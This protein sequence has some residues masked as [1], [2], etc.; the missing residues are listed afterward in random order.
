MAPIV[1]I[2]IGNVLLGDD[3]VGVRVVE[4]LGCLA[5][6]DPTMLP[7]VTHLLDG[8]TLG[9]DLMRTVEGAR[10][11]LLVDGVDLGAAPG[12]VVVLRGDEI[13]TAG[14]RRPGGQAG[15]I[16]E[17]LA[18]ARLMG[19]LT[20]PVAMVG[21]QVGRV[22]FNVGLTTRVEAAVPVA[23]ETARMTLATM[24]ASR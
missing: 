21:V 23:V 3:A 18:L 7:P 13:T 17:L 10:A 2:G 6:D 9:L 15:G 8:G 24:E 1:V 14:A 16:G 5:E 12:E 19:W 11:V 20:G 4:A 22:A